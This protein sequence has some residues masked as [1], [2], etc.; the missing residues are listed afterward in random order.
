MKNSV[1][2]LLIVVVWGACNYRYREYTPIKITESG[3]LLISS[4]PWKEYFFPVENIDSSKTATQIFLGLDTAKGFK[5]SGSI[6][7]R[8]FVSEK[9][10]D[11]ITLTDMKFSNMSRK[12]FL[13]RAK[14]EYE[15]IKKLDN[16]TIIT[17]CF[18]VSY[19]DTMCI[20]FDERQNTITKITPIGQ[21]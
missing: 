7:E 11:T 10:D 4:Y 16:D 14:V 12:S 8:L 2:I 1:L 3:I 6:Q 19:R 15:R 9:I 21:Y 18:I 17:R 13:Y 5:L 20:Y